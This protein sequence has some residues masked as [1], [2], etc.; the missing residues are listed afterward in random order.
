MPLF[1]DT[2]EERAFRLALRK[3]IAKELTPYREEWDKNR[4]VP[5][6]A[7]LKM[8]KQGFLCAWLPEEYGGSGVNFRYSVILGQELVRGDAMGIRRAESLRMCLL[9]TCTSMAPKN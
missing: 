9:T 1:E 2:P 5:R 3:F 7:W 4:A 8:G 6:E